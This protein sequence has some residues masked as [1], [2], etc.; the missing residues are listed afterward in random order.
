MNYYLD[1]LNEL[2]A[3]GIDF[4]PLTEAF[5]KREY[6]RCEVISSYTKEEFKHVKHIPKTP[7]LFWK[8]IDGKKVYCE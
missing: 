6:I 5:M 1:K 8:M 4:I 7:Y 2:G 3:D